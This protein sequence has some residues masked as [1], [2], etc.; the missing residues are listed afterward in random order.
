M[1]ELNATRVASSA[2]SSPTEEGS[3]SFVRTP[4]RSNVHTL[5]LSSQASNYLVQEFDTVTRDDKF[6][7]EHQ[8]IGGAIG[9]GIEAERATESLD[10]NKRKRSDTHTLLDVAAR[11]DRERVAGGFQWVKK[12]ISNT[13]EIAD[14]PNTEVRF[15]PFSNP[16]VNLSRTGYF[17]NNEGKRVAAF[18][19]MSNECQLHSFP[20]PLPPGTRRGVT[21]T[22]AVPASPGIARNQGRGASGLLSTEDKFK[23]CS[24]TIKKLE[25]KKTNGGLSSEENAQLNRELLKAGKL[26]QQLRK[27]KQ[28][29]AKQ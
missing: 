15:R 24:E 3:F 28:Q 2:P 27:E 25:D 8:I 4:S 19:S 21:I 12:N 1:Q 29:Q 13:Q 26:R 18:E 16:G 10:H 9:G 7:E 20:E 14:L 22:F 23:A 11:E 5:N 17:T 6:T